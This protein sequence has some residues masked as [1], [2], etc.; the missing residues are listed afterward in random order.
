MPFNSAEHP[1]QHFLLAPKIYHNTF[2]PDGYGSPSVGSA[3]VC[4]SSAG[5]LPIAVFFFFLYI[6][7]LHTSGQKSVDTTNS[8]HTLNL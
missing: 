8:D 1:C 5:F 6:N 7:H 2:A 4:V 3:V